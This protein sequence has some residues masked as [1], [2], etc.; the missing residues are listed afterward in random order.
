MTIFMPDYTTH[1]GLSFTVGWLQKYFLHWLHV[2]CVFLSNIV[3]H[4]VLLFVVGSH[5]LYKKLRIFTKTPLSQKHELLLHQHQTLSTECDGSVIWQDVVL[6]S[7]FW[8]LLEMAA[9]TRVL[10][11]CHLLP[12]LGLT[13]IFPN[14]SRKYV[15][16]AAF[17]YTTLG[18]MT[19]KWQR[20]Y[21]Q[22]YPACEKI[23]P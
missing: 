21:M 15:S 1:K 2:Y 3:P 16:S 11:R 13:S 22:R 20:H 4:K 8:I 19:S 12:I 18:S 17:P 10:G 5:N 7:S 23:P 14:F 9:E 6:L